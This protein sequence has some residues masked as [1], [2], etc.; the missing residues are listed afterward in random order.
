[1]AR[2]ST[3]SLAESAFLP[4]I[5]VDSFFLAGLF[6]RFLF[7]IVI[8]VLPSLSCAAAEST[9]SIEG[10]CQA[11]RSKAYD[12]LAFVIYTDATEPISSS[13]SNPTYLTAGS[14]NFHICVPVIPQDRGALG[15]VNIKIQVYTMNSTSTESSVGSRAVEYENN[16]QRYG[17]ALAQY[18]A[19]KGP[20]AYPTID[21]VDYQNYH[22]CV[23]RR[24]HIIHSEF[25]LQVG[26]SRTD[27][28]P[29]R[30]KFVFRR[31]I[32]PACDMPQSVVEFISELPSGTSV[33][34]AFG[35]YDPSVGR[36]INR[37]SI[38]LQ[39]DFHAAPVTDVQYLTYDLNKIGKDKCVRIEA[40]YIFD[41]RAF[42]SDV[43]GVACVS[44]PD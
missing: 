17:A 10:Q 32:L 9:K 7:V 25:H 35:R 20:T 15:A 31:D 41:S 4:M 22:G 29:F 2:A 21:I 30:G 1:L 37:R 39:Y 11:L 27:D 12:P 6:M 40:D 42:G 18:R 38:I 19:R 28:D 14:V 8:G 26:D 36:I 16:T 5:A 43:I 3:K 34:Q 24:P 44:P 13:D 23:E 33:A